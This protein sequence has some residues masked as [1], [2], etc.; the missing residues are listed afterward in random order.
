MNGDVLN[1]KSIRK[2]ILHMCQVH[3]SGHEFDRVSL[4]AIDELDLWLKSEIIR[5][6][7]LLPSVG[8]TVKW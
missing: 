5:R 1:R 4:Q 8:K 3:R 2:F 6:V 7:K